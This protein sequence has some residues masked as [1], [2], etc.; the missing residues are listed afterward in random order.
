M[1]PRQREALVRHGL[2]GL[3]S[4]AQDAQAKGIWGSLDLREEHGNLKNMRGGGGYSTD[5]VF[6]LRDYIS[7][8]TGLSHD[9][10]IGNLGG[11]NHF[12]EI[13]VARRILHGQ[14]AHD[15]AT[16]RKGKEPTGG[17]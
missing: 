16:C 17:P 13:Q 14:A 15:T 10:I 2:P 7:A 9:S 4:T 5:S 1:T 8:A 3:L 12:A 11:G 6:A